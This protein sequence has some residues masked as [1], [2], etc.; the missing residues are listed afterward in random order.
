MTVQ[1]VTK[2]CVSRHWDSCRSVLAT[3]HEIYPEALNLQYSSDMVPDLLPDSAKINSGGVFGRASKGTCGR[4]QRCSRR[5]GFCSR[6]AENQKKKNQ[7]NNKKN[8]NKRMRVRIIITSNS[9]K[10]NS[11]NNSSSNNTDQQDIRSLV[12]VSRRKPECLRMWTSR[13]PVSPSWLV[14]SGRPSSW[15][16]SR[17]IARVPVE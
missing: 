2:H 15:R 8:N 13:R 6:Q 17:R 7:N 16:R 12:A 3:S 11:N 14:Q 4:C 10:S 9:S 1:G 5:M